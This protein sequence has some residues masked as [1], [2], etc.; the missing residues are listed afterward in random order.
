MLRFAEILLLLAPFAAYAAWRMMDTRGGPSMPVLLGA[1]I[2]FALLI[3][4]LLWTIGTEG[5]HRGQE[6]V[7]ARLENGRIVPGH[8]AGQ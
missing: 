2:A 7:P 6:Y 8:A 4:V 1:A 3:A 5:L